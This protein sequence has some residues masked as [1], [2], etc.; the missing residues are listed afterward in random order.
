MSQSIPS[1]TIP[2]PPP[3]PR[4]TLVHLTKNRAREPDFAHTNCPQGLQNIN[5][6]GWFLLNRFSV[7]I[8]SMKQN[9]LSVSRTVM[10]TEMLGN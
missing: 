9:L 10:Y 3:P 5:I 4:A 7:S 1:I 6:R 8:Q 2:S